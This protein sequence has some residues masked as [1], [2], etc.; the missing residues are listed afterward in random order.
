MHKKSIYFKDTRANQQSIVA[1]TLTNMSPS[2]R[3][4]NL[5]RGFKQ[6]VAEQHATEQITSTFD[7]EL[8]K[9]D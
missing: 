7:Y 3:E 9:E 2:A 8:V 1:C 4:L 5:V 6:Y